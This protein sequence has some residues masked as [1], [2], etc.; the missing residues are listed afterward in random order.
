MIFHC[1][2]FITLHICSRKWEKK[3]QFS[4]TPL[5][6][7]QQN[8]IFSLK[9]QPRWKCSISTWQHHSKDESLFDSMPRKI[10][11]LGSFIC[12]HI[13]IANGVI[14]SPNESRASSNTPRIFCPTISPNP[15]SHQRYLISGDVNSFTRQNKQTVLS[16]CSCLYTLVCCCMSVNRNEQIQ[17]LAIKLCQANIYD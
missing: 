16:S 9:L 8:F 6:R 17:K 11:C 13:L 5:V 2:T 15:N 10:F 4:P 7:Y 1:L 3:I 12:I 14:F